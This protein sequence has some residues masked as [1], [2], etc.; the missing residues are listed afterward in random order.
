M[1]TQESGKGMKKLRNNKIRKLLAF[2]VALAL[3]VSCMPS[4][5]TISASEAFGDGTED[6]FTDGEITSEPAAE[7]STPDVSSADQEETEQAQQST[8][9]YEND[10]V[11]VTAEALE[12]GALPQ[13]T[14]LKA[15]GVNENSS[16]SYDTVSQKLSAAATDKGS[17]LRGFFAYD[18]YFADG[19]GNRVEPNGRVRVTFEY[20]TPAAPELTDAASTSVTVE[21]LHY[22]S[23]TGDTDV[24]TLQANEDLKVLN[25]NEGKQIQTLQVETGNAAVFA[26]MWDSPETADV[27]A[28]AVSGN[29]DEVPIASEELTDGMDIS[30]EPEQDAAET[31]AAENP[32]VTPDAEPSEAPAENPDAEPT[33]APAEDPDVVEEP[34][35]DIASPDE[36]PAADE[37]GETS[38]IKVL[39]DDTN[40]RVS[41]SIEAEVLATVN[42]GTQLTLLDTVTAEDGA[43]WYKVSWEGTEA[44]IRSDMAQVVD[45]SD[46]AEEPEDVQESEEVSYSQEVGNVVVTATAVKGV[47]PEGAQFVVTPIEKGSD[48]YADIEKQ[49]HE[50]AEN[51]SYTVAGFLAYDISFLN[52]DGTKIESQNGSVR[53]SIAYK[54]AEIPEDVAETDTAQENMNVSLVHFVEDANGNVTEVV[55]MSNDGQAEVSTT[56]NGEIESANFETESFSTFSVVWLADDFTSVQTTSSYDKESTVDSAASGITINMFNYDTNPINDDHSLKFSN[57]KDQRD[58]YNNWTGSATPYPGIMKNTL[59][60]DSYPTLNKGKNESSSY[61]F[62]TTSGTGKTVYSDANYLFKKDADGYYEYDSA[63]NF[64]QFDTKT[65]NFTVYKVPGSR[66]NA[67]G[68]QSYPKHGSFFP[69][70]TLGNSVIEHTANGSG[71]YGISTNPDYHFGM[72]MSAKFIQPKDGKIQGNDMVFEFSGD[73]DV[74]VYIDGVLVLDIGGVHNA[75]SGSINFANGNVTVGNNNNLNLRQLF[76][77]AKT[78]GDF[79]SGENRFA[80]YTMHTINFYYLER[81]EGDSNCKL[82]FNL[83]TVPKKSVTVEKQLSNTDKEKYADVEF[84]FQLLVQNDSRK[85]VPSS[86]A[87]ILSDGSEVKFKSETINDVSYAN[88][89]T[90]KPGQHATFSGLEENKNYRVQEL[91]VSNDKYDQVLINGK[92]ATNQSGNVISSVAT[93]DSRPWVTFT[94][95]CSEENSRKLC[96]TK[97]IK[98]DI[99]VND[100]FDFEIKLNSQ[101]YTGNYY[102]QDSE[103]NY[104]TSEN[105]SLKKATNKTVCGKAVNGVVPSVPAGYTVVLEQILAGT[106]FEVNEI[107]LNTKD[108]GNPEYSIEEAEVVSTTDTASGKIKLGSDAKV[109]VTNTR[110]N[111][112]SLEITKVNTSNQPLSG[113]KFTLTLDGDSAKTYNVTSDE[114]GLLKFENLSVG[115]YTLTETEAPSGY[116]KSTES[117]K[118]KVSVENNKATAKLYKADGTTE[119]ENKQITNYTEKEE[120]ENNLT[121]SKTAEVVDYENRIYKINLNAETTGREGDVRAQGASVVMVLDAS[122]SMDTTK[123]AALKN[124]AN[125]FIDT[126]KS[127]SSESEI[128]IIW[129]SGDEGGNTSITN[130]GFKQLNKDEDVSSL[131]RTIADQDASGGTPMGVALETARNQLS[132]AKHEKNKYV[133]FMTDGLPGHSSSNNNW[134]CMVANNAVNNAK[135]IKD[136]ATTLY[137]VGVGLKARDTFEWKEGHSA[138][139]EDYTGHEGWKETSFLGF[140]KIHKNSNHKLITGSEF[141]SEHIATKSSDGTKKYAYDTSGLNDLVNTFNVIAGSIGDLFTVQPKEIVDVIDARFKLTNDGLNDL[142]TNRRLGTGKINPNKDGSKEIIWTDR[143]TGSEV[144]KVTIVEQADGTTKITWTGQVARIGN[145]A[146]ENEK[147]KGWNASFRIQAKDDFIGGNMIPTNGADSGIHLDGG[148]IKKFE[149]P[150]VNVKLLNLNIGSKEITVFKGDPITAKNFGNELAETIKVVQL[151]KK[152][153]LT[154]VKPMDAGKNSVKLPD[155]TGDDI[156][157]LNTDKELTIGGEG[158]YQYI[159][160]GSNDAVG[161]FTYTYKIVKG[162]A[163][164]HLANSVG[165]KVEEY[166][167]TVTYH[168]YSKDERNQK[169]ATYE[170]KIKEPNVELYKDE[171]APKPDLVGK[172]KGGISVDSNVASTGT[173]IVNVIA[174]ELQIV[175]K[176]D[177]QAEK[178]ETFRFTI[179]DKNG[180]V[181]TATAKIAKGGKEATA[182]FELVDGANA[183]LE[184][185]NKK[186]SELSQGAYVVKE[187]SDNTSYELQSIATG[188]GTNCAS[189]IT[190]D[191]SDGI[192]FDMGTDTNQNKVP[193]NGNT[194]DGRVGIAEFTNKKT[195]VNIDFEK[196]DAE[197]NTKKLSGAE[198]DLYKANTDGEQTGDPINQYESDRNGKVSIENLPIGNYVLVER[199][200]PAG[201]QLSAKPWKIIVGSDRNITVTHGDDTVSPNGNEKIYQ[202][203]NAKLYSLP[204]SGGPG[205]YGFTISGVAILAT[206]LLLFI[207]NKRREEEAKRS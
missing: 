27:E 183:K 110:N 34:A 67:V 107:N 202:L 90:L 147:D 203:T 20:K 77:D 70:N 178:E 59:G 30:D 168:P 196:V 57:G 86:T 33:E 159:Y 192:T 112:A 201:Y 188:K 12:D 103:G 45:S 199:K 123:L 152:E 35:E 56:D 87:G 109:T 129:Y 197:T 8:L 122:N 11:K 154:A 4:A 40:L 29:E 136:D 41:P 95:K 54:E 2:M 91:D 94:N 14:A 160:P 118:V 105:G 207:N 177:V 75:A 65:K 180:D 150:S 184:L 206:A 96:I 15:D 176:L 121:S 165:E 111:V 167:L 63:E 68:L 113:A 174:G 97:K 44:Y 66:G 100:K 3:M 181:A 18:V 145:T 179:T 101:H 23:S 5:Y 182:V 135:L 32:E 153:T 9:T 83:P 31:P 156:R 62:S 133:V 52:D 47:I 163:D 64:A 143:T 102:L 161:Y 204:E 88:V 104:Y 61:L 186:L 175:K 132:S 193:Q 43:T 48:Q 50:G 108:Y 190:E 164:E 141:L 13:N 137:T 126:L 139:T 155:L 149:Q 131:K 162:N 151:N 21:K 78:T 36:V 115:T 46:E 76:A 89:F 106:S 187:S 38:L 6:I 84:K 172:P 24:N 185:D 158:L 138:T 72:T 200:A 51:E 125:T 171:N 42:A 26:V 37:N 166:Q 28:E 39:G 7:E 60:S 55:N 191:L 130:S 79:V 127:K 119:I 205:T 128:A 124:A 93:V 195:V 98:G 144:G 17:S 85:Y 157:K 170:P 194:T 19:D 71:I 69:F 82:K 49:L 120:A 198:F 16:V 146:T 117:Y 116:V 169:L 99:P 81:G 25:V 140:T 10:S 148:G 58:A 114:N 189:V 74:W 53:V 1:H 173:Y 134:N 73:D 92:N 80:D 142:A 22:N